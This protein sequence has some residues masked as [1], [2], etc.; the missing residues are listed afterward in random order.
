MR[1]HATDPH[2]VIRFSTF[3]AE[4]FFRVQ[5]KVTEIV[6]AAV[7]IVCTIGRKPTVAIWQPTYSTYS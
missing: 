2:D 7:S 5:T 6:D 3:L 4:I 1:N